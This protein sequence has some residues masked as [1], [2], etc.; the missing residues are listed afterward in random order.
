MMPGITELLVIGFI[1]VLL[2]GAKK[3]PELMGGIGKGIK[4]LKKA[5]DERQ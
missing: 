4:E 2:F 1:I 3:V 5:V